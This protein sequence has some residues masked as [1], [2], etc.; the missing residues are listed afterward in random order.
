MGTKNNPGAWDCY[1]NAE[2]DEPMFVLLGRDP[3]AGALVRL[4]AEARLRLAR[5]GRGGA[6]AA[7][8]EEARACADAMDGWAV[9]KGKDVQL[10]HAS[11]F[12]AAMRPSTS[13]LV[14]R[15]ESPGD[16]RIAQAIHDAYALAQRVDAQYA[17]A[18]GMAAIA[19]AARRIGVREDTDPDFA[20]AM[21][22][23]G[24][25]LG[26]LRTAARAER[27]E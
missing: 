19:F 17:V 23:M 14:E 6:D 11:V 10:A 9:D 24:K 27:G 15:A 7:K 3:T 20:A 22:A 4:W 5:A 1:A 12:A 16:T 13:Y 2:P 25:V 18:V 8:L 21:Q 26:R